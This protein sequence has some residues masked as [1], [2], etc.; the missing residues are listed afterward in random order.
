MVCPCRL[1]CNNSLVALLIQSLTL[2][3]EALHLSNMIMRGPFYD[4]ILF[5]GGGSLEQYALHIHI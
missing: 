5:A 1:Y 2:P 4:L 3:T